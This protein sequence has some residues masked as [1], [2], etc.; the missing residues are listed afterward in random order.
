MDVLELNVTFNE[1]A[2][3][4]EIKVHLIKNQSE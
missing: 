4:N 3:A 2:C 1:F